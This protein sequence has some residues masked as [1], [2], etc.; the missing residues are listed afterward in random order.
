MFSSCQ[1]R[2]LL[3][4]CFSSIVSVQGV[5]ECVSGVLSRVYSRSMPSVSMIGSGFF[6]SLMRIKHLLKLN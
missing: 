5:N 3:V 1:Y 4:L 2:F 6:M